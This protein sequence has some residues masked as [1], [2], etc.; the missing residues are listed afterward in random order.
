MIYLTEFCCCFFNLIKFLSVVRLPAR[1]HQFHIL[2][3][4]S[5]N[6]N[7]HSMNFVINSVGKIFVDILYIVLNEPINRNNFFSLKMSFL[8]FSEP[9]EKAA[10]DQTS[11]LSIRQDALTN[12]QMLY[13]IQM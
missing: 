5:L 12:I 10:S 13:V 8:L 4:K 9:P 6:L 2:N 11:I 3:H 7:K 1:I